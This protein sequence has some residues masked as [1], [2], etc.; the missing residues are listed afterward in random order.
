MI[1]EGKMRIRDIL[2][3]VNAAEAS[4]RRLDLAARLARRHQARLVG[5]A[6]VDVALPPIATPDGGAALGELFDVMRRDALAEAEGLRAPFEETLRRE[7][8][9]GEWCIV[10]GTGAEQIARHGRMVDLIVLGQADPDEGAPAA[11]AMIEGALFASGRPVLVV[12]HS[13]QFETPGRRVLI[14]WADRREA[15]RVVHDAL[16]LL[17]TCEAATVLTVSM[18]EELDAAGEPPGS[19][20]VRHLTRHGVPVTAEHTVAGGLDVADLLLNHASENSADLL[21]IGAYGHSRLRELVLG[22]VT[23]TILR[24]MTLP[25]LMSH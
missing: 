8:I 22:G 4:G 1:V 14:G 13:G 3:H 7:A 16:P 20:I 2:V 5:L 6:V 12:P 24:Q 10:E 23:R 11:T 18:Q 19:G 9:E 15:T 25:V 17:A 21:V